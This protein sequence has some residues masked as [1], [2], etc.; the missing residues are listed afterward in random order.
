MKDVTFGQYYPSDSII[1]KMNPALKILFMIA[2]IVALFLVKK[3][4]FYG[5]AVCFAFIVI[6]I[7]VARIPPMQILRSMKGIIF[8]VVFSAVLNIFFNK[9]GVPL[10]YK[11]LGF[12]TI[13]DKGLIYAGFLTARLVLLVVG[14]SVLTFTT[15]PVELADGIEVLL[16]PL[17]WI[18][19]PVHEFALVMSIALR[20]IPTLMEETDRI[21]SAQKA[22][23]AGLDSGNV[24]KK[25]KALVPVLVPLLISAF[26]RADELGDAMDARCYAGSK[27]RTKMK[28]LTVTWRDLLGL[29]AVGGAV[30]GAVLTNIFLGAII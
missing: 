20:F 13:T 26:R 5:L 2:Y 16:T 6:V 8:L 10:V 1:H 19:I 15:S 27:K 21:M 23:G 24:F 25:A 14:A 7:I 3:F 18:K 17:K 9:D 12:V 22:R 29:L 4:N 30:A 28:K 11:W